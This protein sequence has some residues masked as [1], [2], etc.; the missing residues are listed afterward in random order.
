MFAFLGEDGAEEGDQGTL[1][2]GVGGENGL[3]FRERAED[4]VGEGLGEGDGL[5]E[6]ADGEL[7]L[8]GFDGG[9]VGGCEDA[10]YA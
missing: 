5:E 6:G 9:V 8:A 7:V 4:D 1:V 2:V 10:V 3:G